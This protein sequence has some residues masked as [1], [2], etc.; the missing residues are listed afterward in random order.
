MQSYL[1]VTCGAAFAP[2]AEPPS[3]CPICLDE[4]QYVGPQGQRWTTPA[5]LRE[6][7]RTRVEEVEPGLT[8]VGVE[9]AFAIGQRAL[10][11]ESLLWECVPLV[12]DSVEGIETIAS[13]HPHLYSAMVDWAD[14]FDARILLH[15]ADREWA[16]RP[17]P[18][19]EYWSGERHRVSDALELVRVGGHFAGSTVCVWRD[20]A[21]GRGVLLA[22]DTL[23]VAADRD[24]VSFMW[25]Y[26]N[27][28][29][30]PAAEV[31]RIRAVVET[32]E[33]DRVYGGWWDR[34]IETGAKAKVLRSADRYIDAVTRGRL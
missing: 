32:L 7:H 18:R 25:S 14:R 9:P 6:T 16:M 17:S 1:C 13:S 33:F 12:D 30:L 11:V 20:G 24:W 26:P 31:E 2:S 27:M 5:E 22:G 4:R 19:I 3:E 8:G 21:A 10:R 29:P 28:I 23:Q 15:E 34:V